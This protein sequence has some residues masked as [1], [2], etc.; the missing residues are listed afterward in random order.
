MLLVFATIK[1]QAQTSPPPTD[2]TKEKKVN[3]Q[4][5]FVKINLTSI[6]LKN[7]AFQYERVITK[8]ISVALSYRFMPTSKMPFA[9]TLSN[10]IGDD[11]PEAKQTIENL[12]MS[13][14]AITPEVRFYLGKGY[15]KGFYIALFYRYASFTFEHVPF[16]YNDNESLDLSGKLTSNTGGIM[17]GAQWPLGKHFC[18]DLLDDRRALRI[19]YW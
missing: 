12:R 8:P 17:F 3:H 16:H 5:N 15:G 2:D 10:S 7:Y 11:D 14:Y 13:N 4:M 19:W 18:L 1:L 6:A 9:G